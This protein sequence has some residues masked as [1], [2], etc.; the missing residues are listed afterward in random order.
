[1]P[2]YSPNVLTPVL[3]RIATRATSLLESIDELLDNPSLIRQVDD[4]E[5]VQVVEDLGEAVDAVLAVL[6]LEE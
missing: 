1:M 3:R 6:E 5:L 4:P 2:R